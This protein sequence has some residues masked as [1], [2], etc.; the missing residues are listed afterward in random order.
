MGAWGIGHFENDTALDWLGDYDEAP[1][2]SVDRALEAASGADPEDLDADL[3]CEAL[4][5]AEAVAHALGR[6]DPGLAPE[7]RERLAAGRGAVRTLA[8]AA[9]RAKAAVDRVGAETSELAE[10]WDEADPG[11]A[12][13]WR[14]ALTALRARLG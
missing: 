13:A 7:V 11:D 10:L 12:A 2:E 5:A 8:E 1:A 14:A 4:A 6:P 9:S 3:A